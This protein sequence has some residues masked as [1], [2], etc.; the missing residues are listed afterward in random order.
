MAPP[1]QLSSLNDVFAT[2]LNGALVII[3]I[4]SVIMIVVGGISYIGSGGDKEGTAKAKNT[5]T[6][7]IIGLIVA[8][9]AWMILN[10]FGTIIGVDLT[11]FSVCFTGG[12]N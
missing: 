9:S 10:I 11:N 7:A 12:C 4:L 3:G 6:F 1:A 5:I 8:I 2:F